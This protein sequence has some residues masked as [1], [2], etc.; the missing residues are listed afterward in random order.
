M[1][2][3]I[4]DNGLAFIKHC[5]NE[6]LATGAIAL[7]T[8]YM[9]NGR[10]AIGYGCDLSQ[11]EAVQYDGHGLSEPQCADLLKF[12]INNAVIPAIEKFVTVPLTQGQVDGLCSII[13]NVGPGAANIKDGI[14][15]LRNGQHSTLL[16]KLN[17]GDYAGAQA[18]FELWDH[19]NGVVSD[20]ILARRKGEAEMFGNAAPEP[21]T[22]S[23]V[24]PDDEGA[25]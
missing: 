6:P 16:K 9:D 17:A 20:G 12:R 18:Q 10:P 23:Q 2:Y 5:E 19:V 14:I 7:A 25:D 22:P 1:S 11:E 4:S 13:Y 24:A 21:P 15:W 3:T 8:I